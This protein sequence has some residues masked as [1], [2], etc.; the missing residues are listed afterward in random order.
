[1]LQNQTILIYCNTIICLF[2]FWDPDRWVWRMTTSPTMS[3]F[4]HYQNF[5]LVSKKERRMFKERWGCYFLLLLLL[6]TTPATSCYSC[7]CMLLPT[8]PG[9]A[10]WVVM[11]Q[12]WLPVQNPAQPTVQASTNRW[13]GRPQGNHTWAQGGHASAKALL[14]QAQRQVQA[15]YDHEAREE[16]AKALYLRAAR[17]GDTARLTE[18][19]DTGIAQESRV[20]SPPH[21]LELPPDS[22]RV[23]VLRVPASLKPRNL[24]F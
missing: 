15:D 16:V 8:F 1:M 10:D 9:R 19:R 3:L 4:L 5:G 2:W 23:R 21:H 24:K 13:V 17:R 11:C 12:I 20:P 18:V 6:P 22:L 7:Y 14:A